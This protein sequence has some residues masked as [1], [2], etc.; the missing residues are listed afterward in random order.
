MQVAQHVG[1]LEDWLRGPDYCHVYCPMN[2]RANLNAWR[3]TGNM[4]VQPPSMG[5]I[6]LA[7]RGHGFLCCWD[8]WAHWE[9]ISMPFREGIERWNG[10]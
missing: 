1:L 6:V 4:Y 2:N 8:L 5:A 10:L 7:L 3:V 9:I